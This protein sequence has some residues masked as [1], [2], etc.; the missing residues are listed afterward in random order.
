MDISR[1][2]FGVTAGFAGEKAVVTIRGEVDI[3]AAA[4]LGAFIDAAIASGYLS[5]VVDLADVEDMDGPGMAVVAHAASR[6]AA[7]DG[8]LTVRA[9]SVVT[10]HRVAL[11][12]PANWLRFEPPDGDGGH[13]G[14]EESIPVPGTPVGI[15]SSG[16]V[17]PL[18]QSSA[19]P[20]GH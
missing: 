20:A 15:T 17:E 1:P 8:T 10:G 4:V 11:V 14:K 13:L 3:V 19:I 18:S 2:C 6:L 9:S 12:G 5:V 7:F 16:L